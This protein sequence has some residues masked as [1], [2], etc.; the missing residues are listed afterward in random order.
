[1]RCRVVAESNVNTPF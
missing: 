1:M